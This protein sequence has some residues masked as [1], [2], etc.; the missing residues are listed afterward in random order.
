MKQFKNLIFYIT[1]IGI[2]G[3][4]MY[5]IV[6]S[7]DHL[8][9]GRNVVVHLSSK[10]YWQD[11]LSGFWQNLRHP[12]ALLL[13]QIVVIILAARFFGWIC[14]KI[15]QPSVMG[16]IIAGIILGPSVLGSLIPGFSAT[17]FPVKSLDNLQMLSQIGLV[18]FM[19]VVGMEL[20][21]KVLK[22]KA[23]EAVVISHASIIIPFTAGM[24]LAFYIYR[25]FAPMGVKFTSFGL[26][27]AI[28]MSITAFPVLARIVQERGIHK[29]KL[30]A[31]V[32]TCAAA[33]DITAWS[34]LAVVIAIVKAGSFVSALYTIL[35]AVIYVVIMIMVI[36]PFLKR[37]AELHESNENLSKPIVAIFFFI[38]ILSAYS[39]EIIGIHALFGG[40]L[41]GTIM[42]TNPKFRNLFIEKIE[43]VAMVLFLPLFFVYTGLRTEIGLL[44]NIGLWEICGLIILVAVV[45]K[46]V[47]S[48]F[49]S[50]FV[51]HSWKDSLT[52]GALMNTR[53]LMELVVLNIGYDLG[54]L[55]PQIFAM[56][57]IMALVTTF[58][59]GPALNLIDLIFKKEIR[60]ETDI[61]AISPI[62]RVLISF[63]IAE[64]GPALLRIAH[65]LTRKSAD[66]T[67]ITAM[68]LSPS[69]ELHHY[70]IDEYEQESFT[71]IISESVVLNQ[72]ITTLFK[73]SG[74]ISADIAEV[75]NS[76][77]FNLLL[78][79]MGQS[80]FE[81]TLLGRILGFTT[82]IIKP[83]RIIGTFTGHEGLFE[84]TS[85]DDRIRQIFTNS[86]IP[87][88]ILIDKG[89]KDINRIFLPIIGENDGF[90]LD[91]AKRFIDNSAS[92]I[93]LSFSTTPGVNKKEIDSFEKASRGKVL[94]VTGQS[95]NKDFLNNQD[96]VLMSN[97]GWQHLM[98]SKSL[99][100]Q[101][102]PSILILK[103]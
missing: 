8:E 93:T 94:Q 42:P 44:N 54:V 17:L 32:I 47:G 68:H 18:M 71:P 58:M 72:N 37:V 46:F 90:L 13:A 64:R 87:I 81:G 14:Q 97:E 28:A 20:D 100:L 34:L 21:L 50:K 22:H 4:I 60:E 55:A 5:W 15:G 51:G 75:A 57:V 43:D 73:P 39:T 69:N 76:G 78:I 83:E 27:L 41:A 96:L 40:F 85:F 25:S 53:G 66:K 92:E 98:K 36:K 1:T 2:A 91:Y 67:S 95:I 61:T 99:W 77:E 12:L 56:M 102:A 74:N 33:D 11:F 82:H 23:S 10:G 101:Y 48:A 63:G 9:V 59:T 31:M 62:F 65:G 24:G 103:Q 89:V 88:G 84:K 19:F 70:N 6:I 52:I 7:G 29:T 49:A 86:K 45:G 80:I 16:E 26:F 3:I 30:G 79:G 38:L 35:L